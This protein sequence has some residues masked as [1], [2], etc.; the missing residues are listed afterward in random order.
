MQNGITVK[1]VNID[2][3]GHFRNSGATNAMSKNG[4][5]M[6]VSKK[7]PEHVPPEQPDAKG[8]SE[9]N[10]KD[11]GAMQNR[12]A[13]LKGQI[14]EVEGGA[15]AMQESGRKAQ[16]TS[17]DISKQ[18]QELQAQQ[19]RDLQTI[20]ANSK[21][22]AG[23]AKQQQEN[24]AK[25]KDDTRGLQEA[26]ANGD[27]DAFE[28]Y[29]ASL[30]NNVS[31]ADS[32]GRKMYNLQKS[33]A[34]TIKTMNNYNKQFMSMQNSQKACMQ[35]Q[36]TA[37]QQVAQVADTVGAIS[38]LVSVAGQTMTGIG[39]MMLSTPY[40]AA[41]GAVLV[42]VG[43]VASNIGQY[44]TMAVGITKTCCSAAD[45]DITGALMNGAS[46]LA[47]G[48]SAVEGTVAA[49]GA[50]ENANALAD[51][52]QAAIAASTENAAAFKDMGLT[53][54]EAA[55]MMYNNENF[56]NDT[57][58][59][60]GQEGG[61][62]EI[63]GNIKQNYA[64]DM[65]TKGFQQNAE[66]G[67]WTKSDKDGNIVN[68]SARDVRKARKETS[69]ETKFDPEKFSSN[70]K[71]GSEALKK[72]AGMSAMFSAMFQST[73]PQPAC[74]DSTSS[75]T[76]TNSSSGRPKSHVQEMRQRDAERA[77]RMKEAAA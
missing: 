30:N 21:E 2:S 6:P 67:Q 7:T 12:V 49:K 68:A 24:D 4:S 44:G 14:S 26:I 60:L 1:T 42:N 15:T 33:N 37:A 9:I 46:A 29:A 11:P 40:T 73:Q 66:T 76:K 51:N 5:I 62:A 19:K 54:N 34:A 20:N 58:A 70:L 36:L 57:L 71:K 45:G 52:A 48:A 23:I 65:A 41:V 28:K 59:K 61:N 31:I 77:K 69:G 10:T 35:Q 25:I 56:S 50:I 38:Q 39:N 47:A 16:Q 8:G 75:T 17:A 13:D 27:Q 63:M 55:K 64:D 22:Q 32:Y 43:T 53:K 74:Y 3:Q 18:T 72:A